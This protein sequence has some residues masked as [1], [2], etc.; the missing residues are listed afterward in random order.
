MGAE[1]P[2][3]PEPTEAERAR[4]DRRIAL[5]LAIRRRARTGQPIFGARREVGP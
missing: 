1:A 4:L 3:E 2:D 5:F